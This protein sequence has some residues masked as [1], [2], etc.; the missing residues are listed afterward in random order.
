MEGP[1]D[2][3]V[4]VKSIVQLDNPVNQAGLWTV[5]EIA[6]ESNKR[7]LSKAESRSINM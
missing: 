6:F 1:V 4:D 3:V 7:Q 5:L 2:D